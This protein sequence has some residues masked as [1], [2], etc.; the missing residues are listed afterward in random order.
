MT[1][2]TVEIDEKTKNGKALLAYLKAINAVKKQETCVT[3]PESPYSKEFVK[4]IQNA[5]LEKGR[6]IKTNDDL[7]K[8][9]D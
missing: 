9:I 3:E 5:K 8:S 1:T 4:K 6:E 7:W 2:V